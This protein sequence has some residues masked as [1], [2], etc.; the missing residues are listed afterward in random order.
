VSIGLGVKR[1]I[2]T[3]RQDN[4]LI[5]KATRAFSATGDCG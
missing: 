3:E 4:P 5:P 1:G 2:S